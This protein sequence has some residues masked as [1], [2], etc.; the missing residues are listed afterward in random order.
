MI[1]VRGPRIP[2]IWIPQFFA[3]ERVNLLPFVYLTVVDFGFVHFY[4]RLESCDNLRRDFRVAIHESLQDA[5]F[6]E[7]CDVVVQRRKEDIEPFM[8]FILNK[9]LKHII[10][11]GALPSCTTTPKPLQHFIIFL[12]YASFQRIHFKFEE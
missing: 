1:A 10:K 7:M 12:D 11:M 5:W 6:I 4:H 9:E 2:D 8:I 3:L